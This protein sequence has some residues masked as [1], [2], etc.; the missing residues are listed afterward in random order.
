[1]NTVKR[2]PGPCKT[3][4]LM[5]FAGLFVPMS[6]QSQELESVI[7]RAK[8]SGVITSA[9][10]KRKITAAL[11][12]LRQ[13][14]SLMITVSADLQLQAE[15]TWKTNASS[16]EKLILK[17]TGGAVRGELTGSGKL[18]LTSDRR[19]IKELTINVKSADGQE[20]SITFLADDT[21][22]ETTVEQINRLT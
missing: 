22:A 1:M 11:V 14:G 16:S 10:E 17:I 2:I 12:V 13:D 7:M 3:L 4:L 21:E 18:L 8:G 9:V 6:V 15:G 5:L 19:S 20:I